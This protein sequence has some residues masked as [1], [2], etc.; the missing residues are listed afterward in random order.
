[1]LFKGLPYNK[2]KSSTGVNSP[3]ISEFACV[4]KYL[5]LALT[6][7]I[8]EMLCETYDDRWAKKINIYLGSA[9]EAKL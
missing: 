9:Q 7:W 1:M 4:P 3:V 5:R 2:P 6:A 8:N